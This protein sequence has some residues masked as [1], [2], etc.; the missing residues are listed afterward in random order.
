VAVADIQ[1]KGV[2]RNRTSL[3]QWFLHSLQLLAATCGQ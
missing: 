1:F 3:E 2:D